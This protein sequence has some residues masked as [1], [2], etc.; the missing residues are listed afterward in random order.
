MIIYSLSSRG[1]ALS[2]STRNPR[3]PEWAVIHYLARMHS[4]SGEKIMREL[5]GVTSGTIARLRLKKILVTDT[6]ITV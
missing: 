4:A 2:H 1:Y 5:P 6:G 3:T